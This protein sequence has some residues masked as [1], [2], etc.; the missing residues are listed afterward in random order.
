MNFAT[1]VDTGTA[2]VFVGEPTG[3]RP[4]LYGDVRPVYLPNSRITV[5]VSSRYWE[6]GGPDDTRPWIAPD[7]AVAITSADLLAG[8][9]P[10]LDA[11]IHAPGP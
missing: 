9:D 5:R 8:L 4:N 7:V 6:F 2:A 11:A 1:E 3:G 10:V